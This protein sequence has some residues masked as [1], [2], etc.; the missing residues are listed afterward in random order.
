MPLVV[1]VE[2]EEGILKKA[3]AYPTMVRRD[4]T[5]KIAESISWMKNTYLATGLR[6][7]TGYIWVY[8]SQLRAPHTIVS[9]SQAING[10]M[11]MGRVVSN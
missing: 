11:F 1:V 9:T 2:E 3:G 10:N 6:D 8:V 5:K 4:M 7:S